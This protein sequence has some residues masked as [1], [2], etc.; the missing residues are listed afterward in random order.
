M[1]LSADEQKLLD[2]LEASL[3]A[4]D[5]AL[6][7]K[8]DL[9]P[10]A[11]ASEPHRRWALAGGCFLAGIGL[12][13]LGMLFNLLVVSV[14]GFLVMFAGVAI[15]AVR[16]RAKTGASQDDMSNDSADHDSLFGR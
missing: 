14:F 6:A 15:V 5:P 12:L 1:A 9:Q 10:T 8:F 13:V 2:Q 11:P 4:E 16:P 3:R 7:R